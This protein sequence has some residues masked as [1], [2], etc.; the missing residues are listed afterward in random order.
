MK[1]ILNIIAICLILLSCE[2]F[3]FADQG[4]DLEQ[5]PGYVA[6]ATSGGTVEAPVKDVTEATASTSFRVENATGSSTDITFSFSFGGDAV[7]G[8]D[9]NVANSTATGGTLIIKNNTKDVNDYNFADLKVNILTDGVT[10]GLKTLTITLISATD[11]DGNSIT[12]GRGNYMKVA[13]VN[14]TDID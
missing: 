7:F 8:T 9:F 11:G 3:D 6:Y 4:F 2:D 13:T 14:I 12:V 5:L 1:K 10:D